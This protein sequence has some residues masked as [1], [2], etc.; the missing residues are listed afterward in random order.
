M[1]ACLKPRATPAPIANTNISQVLQSPVYKE[2]AEVRNGI[3]STHN[4]NQ[5]ISCSYLIINQINNNS[6][7]EQIKYSSKHKSSIWLQ[8]S[9]L[10]EVISCEGD[11]L[12]AV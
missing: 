5:N 7:P 9:L 1:A 11:G 8:Q 6:K 4:S 2:E 12:P 10:F 3:N